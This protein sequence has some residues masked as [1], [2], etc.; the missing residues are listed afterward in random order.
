MSLRVLGLD[1]SYTG[2]GIGRINDNGASV[3]TIRPGARTGIERLN[4]IVCE[5]AEEFRW[6]PDLAVIEAPFVG[7][8]PETGLMLGELHGCV[9]RELYR[10][11]IAYAMVVTQHLK[12]YATGSGASTV[13]KAAI[14][15]AVRGRYADRL[16]GPSAVRDDNEADAFILA[17][18]G[19]HAYGQPLAPV[20]AEHARAI[21]AVKWPTL[22]PQPGAAPLSAQAPGW[23]SIAR[24][25]GALL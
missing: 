17:A 11:D 2:T 22:S 14:I 6:L 24:P 20:P 7:K 21:K 16:G 3:R 9:K 19:R 1:L 12:M 4:W 25:E 18:L 8:N 15:H 13:E 5:I 23:D 10:H